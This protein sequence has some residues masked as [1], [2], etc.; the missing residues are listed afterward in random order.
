MA[1]T[2][3]QIYIQLVFAPEGRQSLIAPEH[4]EELQKY[5][6][7]IV[8]RQGHKLLA[9]YCMPDHVHLLIGL[10]PFMALSDLVR[11]IKAHSSSFINDQKK[12]VGRFNW[13][14]GYGA[15]SYG[16]SQLTP[17]IRYIRDQEKH[18]ARRTFRDEYV[19]LLER[20]EVNYDP[21]YLFQF[22]ESRPRAV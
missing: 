1:N 5:M 12:V 10:R 7:G 20:F 15:F 19:R 4:R 9:I 22:N 8:T 6:T 13:Q 2:F 3:S 18:H 11:E 16:H 17:V 21:K 14:E